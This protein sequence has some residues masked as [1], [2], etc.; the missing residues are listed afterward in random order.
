MVRLNTVALQNVGID[1][2]LREELDALKLGSFLVKHLD[3]LTADD[4]TLLLRLADAC[5]KIEKTIG[6]IYV[7]EVGIQFLAEHLDDLLAFPLAH[8]SVVDVNAG[9]LLPNCLDEKCGNDRRINAAGKCE[10]H[11]L[12]TDLC[13]D[14]LDLFFYKRIRK[15]FG[16]NTLHSFGANYFLH[17]CFSLLI[18]WY[19][20]Q[21]SLGY[22]RSAYPCH[23]SRR[24]SHKENR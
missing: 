6:S 22:I 16:C 19:S 5:E 12:V 13:A 24:S 21:N 23:R 3:K 20:Y 17:I 11:L 14:F 2:A 7:N 4:L 8:Q 18:R 15:H 9:E 10:Q 1:G